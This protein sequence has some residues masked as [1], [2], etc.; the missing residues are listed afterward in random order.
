MYT[1]IYELYIYIHNMMDI[2]IYTHIICVYIY[3]YIYIYMSFVSAQEASLST[4]Y[5]FMLNATS[6]MTSYEAHRR[7]VRAGQC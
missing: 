3:I 5:C 6:P 1:Y 2:Y 7:R 4:S